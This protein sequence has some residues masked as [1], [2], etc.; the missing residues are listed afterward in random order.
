MHRTAE[1]PK[2]PKRDRTPIAALSTGE[3]AH[4][5]L[6]SPQTIQNWIQD[7]GLPAQRTGGG[8]Y[9]VRA[10]ELRAFMI[11][12]GMSVAEL[13]KDLCG[14]QRF[15]C[16]EFFAPFPEHSLHVAQCE[17]CVVH[18][19]EALRCHE[20]RQH[21]EHGKVHCA[22]ECAECAYFQSQSGATQSEAS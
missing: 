17:S 22:E 20:L 7:R 13:D 19:C 2:E 14:E 5:C 12:C 16:W 3:V 11:Q 15:R 10:E 8:Q 4:Y 18:R 9:R 21:V 1:V 6:V